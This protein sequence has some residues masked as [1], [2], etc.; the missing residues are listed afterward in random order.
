MNKLVAKII[1]KASFHISLTSFRHLIL[2]KFNLAVVHRCCVA[3]TKLFIYIY[4][5]FKHFPDLML[6]T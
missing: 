5:S 3:N 6:I 2:K 1:T 4:I